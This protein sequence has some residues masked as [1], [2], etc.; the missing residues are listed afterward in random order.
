[1]KFDGLASP[2]TR[3]LLVSGA[4]AL[5][6]LVLVGRAVDLQLTDREFLQDHGDARY[7]RV[8]ETEAH[9]GMITD[10]HDEPLA[11]STPVSSVWAK[12]SELILQRKRWD[13]LARLLDMSKDQIGTLVIPRRKREFLY[14]K[15]QVGPDVAEA[16]ARADIPGV[17]LIS[18]YRR[19]YPGSRSRHISSDSRTSMIVAR[20]A[21]NSHSTPRCVEH[22]DRIA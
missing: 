20:K 17:G 16:I 21:S 2:R 5:V 3:R 13:E 9:R 8:I 11:I 12:P 6:A 7:L 18:E 19:F 4:F 15:R 10:R 14:L 22:L 1:M